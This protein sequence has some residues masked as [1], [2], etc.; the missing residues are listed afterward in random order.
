MAIKKF[1]DYLLN[2]EMLP[3]AQS[4][5]SMVGVDNSPVRDNINILLHSV[6]SCTHATPYHALELVRK[7]LAPFHIMLPATNFLDGDAGHEVFEIKQFGDTMGMN[8]QGEVVTKVGSPYY[9]YFEYQLNRRGSFDVFCEIVNEDELEDLL[10]DVDDE[11]EDSGDEP[12]KDDRDA[13]DSFDSYKD[14]NQKISGKK[15]DEETFS[16]LSKY[17][18]SDTKFRNQVVKE[19]IKKIKSPTE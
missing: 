6:T 15:L 10:D 4:E 14:A 9:V 17:I 18:K 11:L 13:S 7:V 2:E 12:D 5:K 19:N 3:Y 16:G 8:N 1:R